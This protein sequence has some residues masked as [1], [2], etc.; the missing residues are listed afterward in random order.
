MKSHWH[1][2][3]ELYAKLTKHALSEMITFSSGKIERLTSTTLQFGLSSEYGLCP[4]ALL[5]QS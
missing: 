2:W 5:R 1:C 3:Y 4:L